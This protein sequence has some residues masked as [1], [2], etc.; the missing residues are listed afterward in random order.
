MKEFRDK[1]CVITGAGSGIG[2]GLAL[3]LAGRGARLAL[4]DIDPARADASRQACEQRGARE[5]AATRST[6]PTAPPCSPMLTRC[7][8][9]S[10]PS[11]S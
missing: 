3:E 7:S 2:R 11:T 10:T 5:V 1:V 6:W 9:G 4:S 8:R